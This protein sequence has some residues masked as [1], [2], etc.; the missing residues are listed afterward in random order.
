MKKF[1][2]DY[3]WLIAI[4]A[5]LWWR[6]NKEKIG[7]DYATEPKTEPDTKPKTKPG[8]ALD[9]TCLA[10]HRVQVSYPAGRNES[11]LLLPEG[12]DY[13]PLGGGDYG[14]RAIENG[15]ILNIATV[16]KTSEDIKSPGNALNLSIR[17]VYRY[18]A[19]LTDGRHFTV[20]SVQL[21]EGYVSFK[22]VD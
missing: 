22:T 9:L 4:A 17:R 3:W 18:H 10:G 20:S 7:K 12:L 21:Q 5:F 6:K 16:E 1:I 14:V 13:I 11:L 2:N 15:D 19:R 8:N